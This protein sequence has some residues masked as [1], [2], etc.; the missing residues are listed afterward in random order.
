MDLD[1]TLFD[2]YH[3][4][5]VIGQCSRCGGSL[6][7]CR[8]FKSSSIE[9]FDKFLNEMIAEINNRNIV[10]KEVKDKDEKEEDTK[11]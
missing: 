7:N 9:A 3:R 2:M 5:L 4:S 6:G 1:R 8:C 10:N 11:D